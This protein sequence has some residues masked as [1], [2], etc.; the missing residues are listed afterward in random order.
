MP[1]RDL[2]PLADRVAEPSGAEYGSTRA[3]LPVAGVVLPARKGGRAK[4][5]QGETVKVALFLPPDLAGNLKALAARHRV[6][7][8]LV[9][10]DWIQAAEVREALARGRVAFENEDVVSHEEALQRLSKW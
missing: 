7:P 6:T 1:R 2:Q 4:A 10:A 9:V 3:P 8:S 5:F